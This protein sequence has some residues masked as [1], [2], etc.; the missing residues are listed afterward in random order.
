MVSGNRLVSWAPLAQVQEQVRGHAERIPKLT[1][2][3]APPCEN[4]PRPIC[5]CIRCRASTVGTH[6]RGG[7]F[8][9]DRLG[10]CEACEEVLCISHGIS[11]P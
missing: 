7:A 5:R 8:S 6:T 4:E 10:S 2:D 9:K 11:S 1:Y 3:R